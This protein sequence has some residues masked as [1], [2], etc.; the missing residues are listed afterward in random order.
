MGGVN[1]IKKTYSYSAEEAFKQL[2]DD[3]VREH[4]RDSYNGT[5]S[6]CSLGRVVWVADKYSS[7]AEKK[8]SE[9]IKEDGYGDKRIAK[10]LDLG[11]V[12]YHIITAVKT[13][14]KAQKKAEYRQKFCVLETDDDWKMHQVSY[15]D[16]KKE[17]EDD[18]VKRCMNTGFSYEVVKKPVN[19]GGS[20][21]I[22]DI[23]PKIR[24]TKTKPK[25]VKAG[26]V[27][28]EVHAYIFYGWA[29]D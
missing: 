21:I 12:E 6:T 15:F 4:G 17:A 14:F 7:K 11:V 26:A 25:S 13:Q 18:A 10:C 27:L 2:Y 20:N 1:F 29:A 22:S 3:A 23:E 5:I 24:A 19:I 16:T 28:K 8:A 9:I